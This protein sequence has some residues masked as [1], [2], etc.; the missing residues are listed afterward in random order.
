V[1]IFRNSDL[2]QLEP[3][4]TC[5]RSGRGGLLVVQMNQVVSS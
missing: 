3:P 1:E 5:Y 4:P 2:P